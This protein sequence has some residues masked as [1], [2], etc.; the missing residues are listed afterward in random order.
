M[1]AQKTLGNHWVGRQLGGA[2]ASLTS[3]GAAQVRADETAAPGFGDAPAEPVGDMAEAAAMGLQAGGKVFREPEPP[4]ENPVKKALRTR[5]VDDVKA[6]NDWVPI[7]LETKFELIGILLNQVWVGPFDEWKI[8][9]AWRSIP[10]DDLPRVASNKLDLW[11]RCIDAGAELEELPGYRKLKSKWVE[12]IKALATSYLDKNDEIVRQQM[13]D[14]GLPL[15]EGKEPPPP[16]EDQTKKMMATQEAALKIASIQE[17]QEALTKIYVG[18]N[19]NQHIPLGMKPWWEPATFNP[20]RPPQVVELP[21]NKDERGLAD[22]GE[23]REV[24]QTQPYQPLLDAFNKGS[25]SIRDLVNLYPMA[26]ALAREGKSDVT[27]SFAKEQDPAKARAQLADALRKLRVDIKQ[28]REKLGNE[29]DPLDLTPLHKQLMEG[30]KAPNSKVEWSLALPKRVATK[31]A[32]GHNLEKALVALA[33]EAVSQLVFMLGGAVPGA[34]G[35]ALLLVGTVAAGAKAQMS[36]EEYEAMLQ[37]SKTA[38]GKDTE[39][40]T[41]QQVDEAKVMADA[42]A[43][44]FAMAVLVSAAAIAG[45]AAGKVAPMGGGGKGG[46]EGEGG[47]KPP[48]EGEHLIDYSKQLSASGFKGTLASR[49]GFGV[50]EGRV[51]GVSEPVAVKVYPA[52][53]N[54]M[55]EADMA[56]ARAASQ[57]G[58]GPKFYGEVPAGPGKRAFA[59]EKL[60]GGF[61]ENLSDAPQ[62]SP[63]FQAAQKQADFYASKVG[64]QTVQDVEAFGRSML[65]QG[66]YY[67]G[68]V[69]GLV[70]ANG[71]WKA[72]DF[73]PVRPL[74]PK[75]TPAYDAAVQRHNDMIKLEA[76]GYRKIAQQ[77]A[78]RTGTP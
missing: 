48:P 38:V 64:P 33:L 7:P 22:G 49:E 17:Q 74:P 2:R 43:A 51:P 53:M 44:A 18:Y 28:T 47:G 19:F 71:R 4:G 60:Q 6:I 75:G 42:D 12:D 61:A 1:S 54:E 52:S 70:D 50:F 59:M 34:A 56:G 78:A 58:R 32:E 10:E 27:K 36:A 8:E 24:V 39:L 63:E 20:F 73:Q 11:D 14:T 55:F 30:T 67:D 66:S 5:D 62:N 35:I 65:Q 29:L 72:I 3:R 40:V 68:E 45:Y 69:Q 26:Y 23:I 46:G 13:A 21:Q 76:D 25:E 77:N 37:A 31:E 15:E 41:P 16:T 57:T 9:E